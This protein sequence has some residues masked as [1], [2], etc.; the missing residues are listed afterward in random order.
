MNAF[1]H[2]L[3][4]LIWKDIVAELRGK[5]IITSILSFAI[6]TLV[7]FNL[8]LRATPQMIL[9]L[10]PGI[11]WISF[12]FAGI[13]GLTRIFVNEKENGNLE[14]LLLSPASREA[15][16][17]GKMFSTLIF[18]LIAQSIILP[19]FSILFNVSL[20]EPMLLLILILTTI[21]FSSIGTLFSAIA[22]NTKSREIMLPML[23]VPIVI[24]III[25]AVVSTGTIMEGGN[26]PD[27]RQW[28]QLILVF[29]ILA[30]V[31]SALTFEQILQE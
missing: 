15:I 5:E 25:G 1:L 4:T 30:F 28:V 24:P 6:L 19:I 18:M 12:I 27:I 22:I 20:F 7:I 23:F 8:A 31:F 17:L 26:W 11:L 21:G 3:I 14:G 29:D 13:L 16:Y 10:S 2:N 9:T